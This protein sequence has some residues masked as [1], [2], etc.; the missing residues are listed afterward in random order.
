[1]DWKCV[2]DV[3]KWLEEKGE[4]KPKPQSVHS[5]SKLP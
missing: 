3:V 4:C 2:N 5:K 1:V